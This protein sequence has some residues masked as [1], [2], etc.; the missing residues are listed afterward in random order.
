LAVL[1][2]INGSNSSSGKPFYFNLN[3]YTMGQLILPKTRR[4]NRGTMPI[5]VN[6]ISL[7]LGARTASSLNQSHIV[8]GDKRTNDFLVPFRSNQVPVE[9]SR[10]TV[11]SGGYFFSNTNVSETN[12]RIPVGFFNSSPNRIFFGHRS[13]SGISIS[14]L[15][16][17]P[18]TSRRNIVSNRSFVGRYEYI[19]VPAAPRITRFRQIGGNSVE[20]TWTPSTDTGGSTIT[21]FRV[22]ISRNRDFSNSFNFDVNASTRSYRLRNLPPGTLYYCRI[23]S[24][25][26]IFDL[27]SS[28]SPWSAVASVR[29]GTFRP[30]WTDEYLP[31]FI[32]S[33]P[34]LN[35]VTAFGGQMSYSIRGSLPGGLSFSV[36]GGSARISGTP[37]NFLQIGQNFVFF[38]RAQNPSGAIEKRFSIRLS[39]SWLKTDLV[40]AHVK[41]FY[42]DHGI[43]EGAISYRI[44]SGSLPAGASIRTASTLWT[45]VNSQFTQ[46]INSV[47]FANNFWLAVGNSGQIRRSTD[48]VTWVTVNSGTSKDITSVAYGDSKWVAGT[49]QGNILVAPSDAFSWTERSFSAGVRINDVAFFFRRN[50]TGSVLGPVWLAAGN[51]GRIFRSTNTTSWTAQNSRFGNANVNSLGVG[52]RAVVAVGNNGQMRLGNDVDTNWV[53][54]TSRFG[55]TNIRDIVFNEKLWVA[56]GN[57][58][59][60]RISSDARAWTT[61]SSGFGSLNIHSVI[62]VDRQSLSSNANISPR[63]RQSFIAAGQNGSLRVSTNGVTWSARVSGTSQNINSLARQNNRSWVYAGNN[64]TMSVSQEPLYTDFSG[65]IFGNMT[66]LGVFNFNMEATLPGGSKIAEPF[67]LD[68]NPNLKRV[69]EDEMVGFYFEDASITKRRSSDNLSWVNVNQIAK[70]FNGTSW[71]D[72]SYDFN[73]T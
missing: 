32:F 30:T 36:S 4:S 64:G 16:E 27:D 33:E 10:Y 61:V 11:R 23:F 8:V 14:S 62:P 18:N 28:G 24:K 12:R 65:N 44:S 60:I 29:T 52:G 53:T 40:D 68:V 19:Q 49:S 54:V 34:Y 71:E 47:L 22:Q 58:G 66:E 43:A 56:V 25:N 73:V 41:A 57:S 72:F 15:S 55:N 7:H 51:G 70:K 3:N 69:T 35:S 26:R 31:E 63:R 5:I 9:T 46:N 39:S 45:S 1:S 42:S 59:Q 50:K 48:T 37:N 6:K 20:V 13:Y 21:G 17:L 2:T 38:I 67:S